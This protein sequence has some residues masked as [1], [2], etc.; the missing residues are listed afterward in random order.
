MKN[1]E[2]LELIEKYPH[3]TSDGF[4]VNMDY[5]NGLSREIF[6]QER[7]DLKRQLKNFELCLDWLEKNPHLAGKWNAHYWKDQVQDAYK[8]SHPGYFHIP[9]GVFILAALFRGYKVT[10]IECSTDAWVSAGDENI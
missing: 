3:L 5:A 1:T 7:E 8:P 6:A 4:G 2:Y 10:K 9:R